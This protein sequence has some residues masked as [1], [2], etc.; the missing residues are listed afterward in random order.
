MFTNTEHPCK[1]SALATLLTFAKSLEVI[2]V[3]ILIRVSDFLSL[4]LYNP[5]CHTSHIDSLIRES[6][7]EIKPFIISLFLLRLIEI[8]DALTLR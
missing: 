5:N 6:Q 2:P 1:I 4:S 8:T 7:I 3:E